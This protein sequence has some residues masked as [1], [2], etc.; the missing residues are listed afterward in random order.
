MYLQQ[1]FSLVMESLKP[2]FVF[3]MCLAELHYHDFQSPVK[4]TQTSETQS[5]AGQTCEI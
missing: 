2:D 1:M 4:E 3:Q 5:V